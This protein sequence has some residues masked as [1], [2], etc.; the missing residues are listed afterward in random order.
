G[1]FG[2]RF[3]TPC[4]TPPQPISPSR[5]PSQ[6]LLNSP[7]TLPL[8]LSLDSVVIP[9]QISHQLSLSLSAIPYFHFLLLR[10]SPFRGSFSSLLFRRSEMVL[11]FVDES[12]Y[13]CC[14]RNDTPSIFGTPE[15]TILIFEKNFAILC[16]LL[17]TTAGL[18][19]TKIV[20]VEEMVVIFLHVLAYNVK[21][22]VIQRDF[23]RSGEI[24]SSHFNLVLF[25]VLR[26]Y[27]ELLKKP[28]LVTNACTD[29]H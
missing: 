25:V 22:R 29:P 28:Q 17:R 14:L 13:L 26:L 21:N 7:I 20:N 23:M 3:K 27:V 12:I 19:L 16:H 8:S 24:I 18:A 4:R 5:F 6:S 15:I 11:R 9:P 10:L 1:L 2:P